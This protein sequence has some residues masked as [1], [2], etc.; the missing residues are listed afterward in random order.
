MPGSI[1]VSGWSKSFGNFAACRN[2]SLDL[3]PGEV[4]G[5][6]GQ[7]GAG[8]S[9]LVKMLSGSLGPDSGSITVGEQVFARWNVNAARRYGIEA[10][11]QAPDLMLGL[12]VLENI[13]VGGE[14][15]H[16]GDFVHRQA[17][18]ESI[19]TLATQLDIGELPLA[20]PLRFLPQERWCHIPILRALVRSPR[21]LLLD[22]PTAQMPPQQIKTF[23]EFLR[24][25][26]R[27]DR[28]VI[29]VSH[30]L[31]EV[32]TVADRVVVMHQ[33]QISGCLTRPFKVT[34]I[35][36]KM[37]WELGPD[38]TPIAPSGGTMSLP[39][40]HEPIEGLVPWLGLRSGETVGVL[41]LPGHGGPSLASSVLDSLAARPRDEAAL[42]AWPVGRATAHIPAE[43]NR[44]GLAHGLDVAH[45]AVVGFHRTPAW[46][47]FGLLSWPSIRLWCSELL[48]K[49]RVVADGTRAPIESL[50]GGNRQR[51][52]IARELERASQVLVAESPFKGLD[53]AAQS[54]LREALVRH[55]RSGRACV[56][57]SSE[58]S[59]VLDLCHRVLVMRHGQ[60]ST[61]FSAPLPD[62]AALAAAMSG[63]R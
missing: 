51:L 38:A 10:A 58:P 35:I 24:A 48:L 53:I 15:V 5:L 57:F 43:I 59:D 9:T 37:G 61:S 23:L 3:A 30:R 31:D 14:Q 4:L 60:V 17:A 46:R 56:I 12:T 33:G 42:G 52:V 45:N 1:R 62:V 21:V 41:A 54:E 22:E 8:K 2:V 49:W 26:V 55:N 7:N 47:H 50:S 16:W 19:R 44:W 11:N 28:S 29:L 34:D 27:A 39:E 63:A 25:W 40:C 18:A 20:M 36:A 32:A 6:V 13:I